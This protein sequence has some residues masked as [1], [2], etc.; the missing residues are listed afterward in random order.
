MK[1]TDKIIKLTPVAV[2]LTAVPIITTACVEEENTTNY[3]ESE[4]S[5]A[6]A[7]IVWS[8]KAIIPGSS[9]ISSRLILLDNGEKVS[10][11]VTW[12]IE[13]G[14]D[15][16]LL[17][18]KLGS[19]SSNVITINPT[20]ESLGQSIKLKVSASINDKVLAT[21]TF[22]IK[23]GNQENKGEIIGEVDVNKKTY[24][25]ADIEWNAETIA[26]GVSISSSKLTL[27]DE[28]NNKITDDVEWRLEEGSHTTWLGVLLGNILDS[29]ITITP[30]V[31]AIGKENKLVVHAYIKNELVAQ[32]TFIIS[33]VVEAP[34]TETHGYTI[35][36]IVW[37]HEEKEVGKVATSSQLKLFDNDN[38]VT[39]DVKWKIEEAQ[40]ESSLNAMLQGNVIQINPNA[41]AVY[42]ENKLTVA[43]YI[44]GELVQFQ[45][46]IVN[47]KEA[48]IGETTQ[49]EI[50]P[51][52]EVDVKPSTKP[53]TPVADNF[54]IG[55]IKWDSNEIIVSTINKSSQL[56]LFNN[57]NE[58]EDV[59]W[60]I[61]Y[62]PDDLDASI[63]DNAINITATKENV[64]HNYRIQVSANVNGKSVAKRTFDIYNIKD[65]E[66]PNFQKDDTLH[67]IEQN[68]QWV[69]PFELET[70][71]WD[72]KIECD[73]QSSCQ[74]KLLD[75][76]GSPL[77]RK[78]NWMVNESKSGLNPQMSNESS[79]LTVTPSRDIY[80]EEVTLTLTAVLAEDTVMY[81]QQ[82]KKGSNIFSGSLTFKKYAIDNHYIKDIDFSNSQLAFAETFEEN[83]LSDYNTNN[84]TYITFTVDKGSDKCLNA[85]IHKDRNLIMIP[86]KEAVGKNNKLVISAYIDGKCVETKE[87][88]VN[89]VADKKYESSWEEWA[90]IDEKYNRRYG[91][92]AIF[93]TSVSKLVDPT[94]TFDVEDNRISWKL[95]LDKEKYT[96]PMTGSKY[97]QV[98]LHVADPHLDIGDMHQDPDTAALNFTT[99]QILIDKIF[100]H[101]SPYDGEIEPGYDTPENRVERPGFVWAKNDKNRWQPYVVTAISNSG[102]WTLWWNP[103]H[104]SI[105]VPWTVKDIFVNGFNGVS[106]SIDEKLHVVFANRVGLDRN[107]NPFYEGVRNDQMDWAGN[108]EWDKQVEITYNMITKEWNFGENKN[109]QE[110]MSKFITT[111]NL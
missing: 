76:E 90:Y 98:A 82:L 107:G 55:D 110:Q 41:D 99:C 89:N 24:S 64:G 95:R 30:T 14:T 52:P 50:E 87:F 12:K 15:V 28:A 100:N 66:W 54:Q 97:E 45:T 88:N 92:D 18:I 109:G 85:F 78:V 21:K 51:K 22:N 104:C 40:T 84:P 47:V 20:K 32:R 94:S 74:L 13:E 10:S 79:V 33:N 53:D 4:H 61:E 106:T 17:G 56:Q 71:N 6:I 102:F 59:V 62:K 7:D 3:E 91:Q 5:Y 105:V 43:A 49:P 96:D 60:K 37:D 73:K 103:I 26:A 80:G 42:K 29:T 34:K 58:A 35:S 48:S 57:G 86:G 19:L 46:F 23:I 68:G 75:H 81:G 101:E 111:Q 27:L 69:Q 65:F 31:D 44:D 16:K 108:K 77:S 39:K 9:T 36:T 25:I 67:V 93:F 72:R 1:K 11:K 70:L 8:E 38:E 2:A 83:L 63:K